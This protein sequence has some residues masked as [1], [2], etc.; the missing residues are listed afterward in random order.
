MELNGGPTQSELVGDLSLGMAVG[1]EEKA[2]FLLGGQDAEGCFEIELGEDLLLE[3]VA[4]TLPNLKLG[5][6]ER[7]GPLFDFVQIKEAKAF[8]QRRIPSWDPDRREKQKGPNPNGFE[9][10]LL[11]P[12]TNGPL[13]L[14]SFSDTRLT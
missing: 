7:L 3:L 14:R 8:A 1:K 5:G 6:A 9:P 12:S 2:G 4:Q 11:Y 13:S 10:P